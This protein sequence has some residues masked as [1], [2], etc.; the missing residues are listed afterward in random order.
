MLYSALYVLASL[1]CNI[2]FQQMG[3]INFTPDKGA[4]YCNQRVCL[5]A[6]LFVC[7]SA[8]ISQNRRVKIHKIV[9]TYYLWPCLDHEGRLFVLDRRLP[10]TCPLDKR[11]TFPGHQ[12]TNWGAK[13]CPSS[14]CLTVHACISIRMLCGEGMRPGGGNCRVGD[15]FATLTQTMF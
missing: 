3:Y 4:M 14:D 1:F 6:C 12:L 13:L 15:A 10:K 11:Q 5:S 8:R 2:T 7:L 9:G